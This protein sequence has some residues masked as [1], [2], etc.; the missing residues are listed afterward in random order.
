MRRE[1]FTV[2]NLSCINDTEGYRS[3]IITES[4]TVIARGTKG[5]LDAIQ[6]EN[7]RAVADLKDFKGVVRNLYGAG[8]RCMLPDMTTSAR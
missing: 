5:E 8:Q 1:S 2:T 7:I 4:L 3:T 6:S